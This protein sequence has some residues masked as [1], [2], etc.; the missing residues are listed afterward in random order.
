M[1]TASELPIDTNASANDMA[2][3]MFGN[4]ITIVSSSYTGATGA[5]GIYSDG[6]A[7]APNLTPS[8][9]G[10]ILSTGNAADV[11]NSSGDVNTSAGTS[12][13]HGN[14]GDSDLTSVSGQT[15]YDA[16]IF[17][18]EF[19][20]E[21]S[22]L[23]MQ[24]VFSSEEYLEYVD[25]G[26]NDAVGIWV[27]GVQAELTVGS[28]DIS[29]DNIN[30]GENENLYIDNAS[31]D[32]TF[33]TEMDG[34]TVTLTLKA[35]V[36]PGESNTIK[37]G[38]ADGGDSSYDSNLLIAGNSVQTGLIATDDEITVN[39]GQDIDVDLLANDLSTTNSV[40]TI[41]HIN[42]QPVA[43]G[44][45][46]TLPSGEV[47]ELTSEGFVLASADDEV[48]ESVFTYTVEDEDGNTDIGFVTLTTTPCFTSGTRILTP[49]GERLVQTLMPGDLVETLDHGP[50]PLLWIGRSERFSQGNDVPVEINKGILGAKFKTAVSPMHRVLIQDP[51]AMLLYGSYEILVPALYLVNGKTIRRSDSGGKVTY[52]HLLFDKH[53]IIAGDG[54]FSESF[55]PGKQTEAS[56]DP[57]LNE[58]LKFIMQRHSI[59]TMYSAR[60]SLKKYEVAVLNSRLT[61]TSLATL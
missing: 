3:A 48:G 4:G 40:L 19:I 9:T 60:P 45:S 22:T 29:I 24:I 20:P 39:I 41:T 54:V 16:A 53:E 49:Q 12:T 17:E 52:F 46:V 28:G 47:I 8:D 42:G 59:N 13:N 43:I 5:S 6:D 55:Q 61:E 10:V 23:T 56:F 11:T 30:D 7:T 14:S 35:T 1:P 21:G 37:I 2:E 25:S 44:D 34:F 50:K 26:F 15:T 58:S 31:T 57:S 51:D 27:N 38:I 36:T 18:A 33:N 32:D